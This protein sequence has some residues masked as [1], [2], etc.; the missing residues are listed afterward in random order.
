MENTITRSRR[1]RSTLENAIH[2]IFLVCGL[3]AV[4]AVL[5]ISLYMIFSGGPA[6]AKIGVSD[7]LFGQ[8]WDPETSRFGI[9]PMILASICAT[10]LAILIA[11][12]VGVCA[13]IF[14]TFLAGKRSGELFLFFIQLLAS[15]PSVV[16]GLL[17][18]ILIVP[19]I[20]KLQ[21]ALGLP[22]SG[23]LTAASI[24]LVIM[25]LPTIISVS[26]AS[27]KA[28]PKQYFDASLALGSSRIQA[29][30][31][32]VLPAAKSGVTAGIVLG[33]G[34][35]IG[36]TMAVLMVAGNAPIMPKLLEPVR[37]LTV[38]ISMEW[39]Y[40]SGSHR[41]ALLGIGLILFIFIMIINIVLG[42]IL[43]KGGVKR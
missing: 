5:L 41:E 21:T 10:G 3:A 39:A 25:I 19:A 18:A 8:V 9:L 26:A 27:I 15:I 1:S 34:R 28:V 23:S 24:V 7:F 4:L 14:I 30:F 11:V 16:Y 22:Q 35:A 13:A 37:L 38:G 6:V 32:V 29:I 43:K 40:S 20:F 36:E 42:A 17:G 2:G 12:P 33:V 31:K